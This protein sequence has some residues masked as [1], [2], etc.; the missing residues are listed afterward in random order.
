MRIK[1]FSHFIK[2]KIS[3][4]LFK[5]YLCVETSNEKDLKIKMKAQNLTNQRNRNEHRKEIHANINKNRI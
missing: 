1:S 5:T 3:A 4:T 2:R